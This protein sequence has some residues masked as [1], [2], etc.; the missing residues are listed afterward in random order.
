M[1]KCN[2]TVDLD[3]NK[4]IYTVTVTGD[5]GITMDY[6]VSEIDARDQKLYED[7]ETY[8]AMKAIEIFVAQH[9][10]KDA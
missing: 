5:N 7:P 3:V 8:A 10:K 4:G 9:E 2:A 6:R 1:L